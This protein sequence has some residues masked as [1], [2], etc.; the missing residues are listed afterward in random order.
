[1]CDCNCTE[2]C[3]VHFQT[4]P[5]FPLTLTFFFLLFYNCTPL[6]PFLSDVQP[7][8]C[9]CCCLLFSCLVAASSLPFS[10]FFFSLL[11][12][13]SL[14]PLFLS[15]SDLWLG[16]KQSSETPSP[17]SS[18]HHALI[19]PPT[20]FE[21]VYHMSPASAG[22]Y[23]QKEASSQQS[24][25]QLS[26]SSSSPSTSSLGRVGWQP[27]CPSPH[28]CSPHPVLSFPFSLLQSSYHKDRS[29]FLS[30]SPVCCFMPECCGLSREFA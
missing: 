21:H 15:P 28:L 25:P 23:L 30:S 7:L 11:L 13:N 2:D 4:L 12:S 17:S 26:S 9:S 10:P 20:N 22:L 14:P 19:S 16:W 1:M 18:R 6:N 24:L 3:I 5:R 29:L 8:C 27:C